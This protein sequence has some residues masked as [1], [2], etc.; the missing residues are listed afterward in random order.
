MLRVETPSPMS[1]MSTAVRWSLK[2]V[3]ERHNSTNLSRPLRR[4]CSFDMKTSSA[5][6]GRLLRHEHLKCKVWEEAKSEQRI[7]PNSQRGPTYFHTLLCLCTLS[8]FIHSRLLL[9]SPA[10]QE[11]VFRKEGVSWARK[12]LNSFIKSVFHFFL[13]ASVPLLLEI[14]SSQCC[15]RFPNA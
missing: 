4:F 11:C 13:L 15:S 3:S 9:P 6:C 8:Y 12:K 5:W 2:R 14:L 7:F 10:C 1:P